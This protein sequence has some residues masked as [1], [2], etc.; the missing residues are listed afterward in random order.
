MRIEPVCANQQQKISSLEYII[1]LL[2][3]GNE[4]GLDTHFAREK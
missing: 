2:Y 1:R 4:Y 3:E